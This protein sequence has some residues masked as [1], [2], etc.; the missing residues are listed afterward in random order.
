MID[1]AAIM[2]EIIASLHASPDATT[3]MA[4]LEWVRVMIGDR[5][6]SEVLRRVVVL[7]SSTGDIVV[8]RCVL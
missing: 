5:F 3:R 2:R 4:I 7:Y 8:V 1:E 6:H